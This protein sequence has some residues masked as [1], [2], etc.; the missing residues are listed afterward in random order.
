MA[1][2]K[3]DHVT[4]EY[5]LGRFHGPLFKA[6]ND[7][8]FEIKEGEV[9]GVIGMNGAGKSTLLKLLSKITEPTKGVITVRGKVA[10]LIEL[11][12][13]LNQELTGRENIY[14]NAAIMGLSRAQIMKKFDEI[15]EFS[16]LKDFIETP[17]KRYSSGM[18]VRLG[19]SIAT[20]IDADILIVDEVLAVGDLA[21]QRKCFDRM[22]DMIKRQGKTVLLVSHNIRQVARLCNKA[23]L[24]DHGKITAEGD[25]S[26]VCNRFYELSD[27][28]I[29]KEAVVAA[30]KKGHTN[31]FSTGEV[32]LL[33]IAL[34]DPRGNPVGSVPYHGDITISFLFRIN[35]ALERPI[36]AVGVHTTDLIYLTGDGTVQGPGS[37]ERMDPGIYRIR[38]KVKKFPFVPGVYSIRLSVS[39]GATLRMIFLA[40]DVMEFNVEAKGQDRAFMTTAFM[41]LDHEWEIEKAGEDIS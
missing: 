37:V 28:K 15:V 32:E 3:V 19:F 13:G 4:K 1:F 17:I 25:T 7:V 30:A 21:F 22:E 34:Q 24:L 39:S 6:L 36:F 41:S 20:A 27:E 2:I 8:N 31:F 38:Y 40:E 23:I 12:A 9:L 16:E 5:R 11:G 18:V 33:E 10:P 35:S 29:R 26:E 14:L